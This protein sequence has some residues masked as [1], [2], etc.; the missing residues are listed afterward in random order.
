M[1]KNV[2]NN[3]NKK[4][5]IYILEDIKENDNIVNYNIK[6]NKAITLISLVITIIVLLILARSEHCNT[7]R[8]EWCIKKGK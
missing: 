4:D 2:G 8:R 5:R 6:S 3:M 1:I 7:N